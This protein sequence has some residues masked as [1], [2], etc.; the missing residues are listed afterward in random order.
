MMDYD[1]V[2]LEIIV[3]P[4]SKLACNSSRLKDP[5]EIVGFCLGKIYVLQVVFRI[6]IMRILIYRINKSLTCVIEW[7]NLSN[8]VRQRQQSNRG[9]HLYASK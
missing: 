4:K 5:K 3:A 1:A 9:L 8:K 2:S 7:A 6:Q